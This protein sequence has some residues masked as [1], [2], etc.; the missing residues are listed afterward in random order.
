ME[1]NRR[2]ASRTSIGREYD[3]RLKLRRVARAHPY[4]TRA[5]TSY[6]AA[7][8]AVDRR[9]VI[10]RVKVRVSVLARR[11][12]LAMHDLSVLRAAD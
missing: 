2:A 5:P 4:E 6:S 11:L 12:P 8:S 1:A 7:T 3:W 10:T 9:G